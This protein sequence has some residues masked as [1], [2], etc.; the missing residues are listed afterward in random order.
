MKKDKNGN[1]KY[2]SNVGNVK[3]KAN[4]K[5]ILISS[6]PFELEDKE[7]INKLINDKIIREEWEHG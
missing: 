5:F 1:I 7:L 3:V 4:D 6:E 2:I